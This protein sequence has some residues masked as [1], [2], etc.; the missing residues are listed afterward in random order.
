MVFPV[1]MGHGKRLFPDRMGQPG[2]LVLTESRTAGD[3]VLLLTYH[4]AKAHAP[5]AEPHDA[6]QAGPDRCC[7]MPGREIASWDGQRVEVLVC[8]FAKCMTGLEGV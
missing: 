7:Q 8:T 4:P 5:V 6:G 2:P 3:G 1:I